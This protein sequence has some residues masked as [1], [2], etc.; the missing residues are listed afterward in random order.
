MLMPIRSLRNQMVIST[1]VLVLSITVFPLFTV[2]YFATEQQRQDHRWCL[3]LQDITQPPAPP[4][5]NPPPK[6][7]TKAEIDKYRAYKIYNDLSGL[8]DELGCG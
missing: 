5:A 3:L 7:A 6:G 1:L 4:K 8:K 2:Y